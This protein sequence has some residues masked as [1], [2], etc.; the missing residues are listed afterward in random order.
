MLFNNYVCLSF[1][2]IF[3]FANGPSTVS[4]FMRFFQFASVFSQNMTFPPEALMAEVRN[5]DQ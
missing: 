1:N 2:N 5:N 3:L 4:G